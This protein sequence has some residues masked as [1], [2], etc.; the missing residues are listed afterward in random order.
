M[1][2]Q[3]SAGKGRW[4]RLTGIPATLNLR[5]ESRDPRPERRSPNPETRNLETWDPKNQKTKP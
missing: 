4:M 5:P 3:T 1:R 2:G